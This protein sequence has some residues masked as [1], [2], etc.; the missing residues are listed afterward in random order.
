M[1]PTVITLNA[2]GAPSRHSEFG[3]LPSEH[4]CCFDAGTQKVAKMSPV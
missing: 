4:A 3:T 1:A 2:V